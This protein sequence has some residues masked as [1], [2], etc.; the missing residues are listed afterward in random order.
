MFRRQFINR[1]TMAAVVGPASAMERKTVTYGVEGFSCVT[2]A[3]GLEVMLRREK[4]VLR[5]DA[6][7]PKAI[8]IIEFDPVSVNETSLKQYIADMGFRV[9]EKAR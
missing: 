2:C 6:S 9:N 3:T 8:V 4:G 7:Y 1:L 5:A